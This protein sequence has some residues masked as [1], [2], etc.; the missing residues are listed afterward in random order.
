MAYTPD[1]DGDPFDSR[2]MQRV[3]EF[4]RNY[5]EQIAQALEYIPN[6]G[7]TV[8]VDLENIKRS[9]ERST[10]VNP[11]E[12]VALHSAEVSRN[13]NL[14][15]QPT[16]AEPGNVSNR[17]RE[18]EMTAGQERT[19][20]TSETNSQSINATSY[21]VT[22]RELIAAMPRAVQ[23]SV[24]IPDDYYHAVALKRGLSEG[25]TDPEKQEFRKAVEAIKAEEER[26]VKATLLTL[27]PAGSPESAIHVSSIVRLDQT[28]PEVSTPWTMLVSEFIREWGSSLALACFAAWALWMVNRSM[29]RPGAEP[30]T[31]AAMLPPPVDEPEPEAKVKPIEKTARDELQTIVRDNPEM[32]ASVLMKWLQAAK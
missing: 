19:R 29:P 10:K 2:L 22:D 21:V 13:E 4:T 14:R 9:T 28:R 16:R 18:L 25:T 12:T 17:P 11:K 20:T 7:V 15:E 24:A 30:A 26:N 8:N 31:A 5:E 1:Q 3:K 32:T 27:I 23:V 6:V